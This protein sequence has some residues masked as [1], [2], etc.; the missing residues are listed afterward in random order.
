MYTPPQSSQLDG[1][2]VRGNGEIKMINRKIE[3]DKNEVDSLDDC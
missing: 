3:K 1:L 2:R